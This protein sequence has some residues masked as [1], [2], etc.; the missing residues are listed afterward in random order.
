MVLLGMSSCMDHLRIGCI[1]IWR[2]NYF[3]GC[4]TKR[5]ENFP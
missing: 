1:S 3:Y 5:C 4:W 2:Y